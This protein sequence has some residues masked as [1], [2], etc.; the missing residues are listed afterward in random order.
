MELLR[1]KNQIAYIDFPMVSTNDPELFI[2]G[3]TVADAAYYKDSTGAWTSLP[4]ADSTSEIGSTGLYHLDLTADEMNHDQVMIKLTSTNAQDQCIIIQTLVDEK[5]DNITTQ[6]SN[7]G[8]GSGGAV[9]FAPIESN[10]TQD[11]IDNAAAV[12]KG[13]GEVGIP[14]TGHLF[15]A[16]QLITIA[17]TTNYNGDF[18]IQSVTTNEIVIT[19]TFVSETFGGSETVVTTSLQ[20]T[21]FVGTSQ[22]GSTFEDV[23]PGTNNSHSI[24]DVGDDVD[25]TYGYQIG[26]NRRATNLLIN[27]DVDGGQDQVSVKVYDHEGDGWDT[28]GEIDDNTIL[29]IPIVAKHTGAG[30]ELGKVYVRYETDGTTPSNLEVFECLVAAVSVNE[31][32]GY[33]NGAIW[34]NSAGTSGT[35]VHLN[36][37][38]DNPC[39]WADAL[40]ISAELG[41][42]RFHIANDVTVTLD[43]AFDDSTMYGEHYYLALGGQSINDS[44]ISDSVIT[45]IASAASHTVLEDCEIGAATIP[46]C[47]AV[48]CGIGLNS[49]T[50]TGASAGQYALIDCYSLVPGSGSPTFNFAGLGSTVGINNRR[51]AGGAAYTLDS[52]CTLSHEVLAGGGQTITPA[53]ANVEIRGIFRSAT[54][55]LGTNNTA[56]TIQQIGTCGPVSITGSGDNSN[57]DI[58]LYGVM[59][60]ISD[61]SASAVV[62]DNTVSYTDVNAILGSLPHGVKKNTALANLKFL[63]L[64]KTTKIP[65][66]GITTS[67][68]TAERAI[69]NGGFAG[70]TNEASISEVGSGVYRL[71]LSAGDLNG[72]VIVFKFAHNDTDTRF[73]EIKTEPSA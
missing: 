23:G 22:G 65:E 61:T 67:E 56:S 66:A 42:K 2:S 4:I 71:D 40:V 47:R 7:I 69:D 12:N 72:D 73:I 57:I 33:A 14:I 27:A 36:G 19:D 44:K 30:A 8:A 18:T 16:D 28:V 37:T 38:A 29:N 46:P 45:G 49:G 5:L 3:E 52:D 9:S 10:A 24:S 70:C 62:T 60:S 17:G 39:P 11:T 64:N 68:I 54:Y 21:V 35:E 51:W 25:V 55:I 15:L 53:G 43:A 26:G 20:G 48:R 59:S 58:N 41:I 34:V 1:T 13:G 50:F 31:S 6:I 63:L 32:V